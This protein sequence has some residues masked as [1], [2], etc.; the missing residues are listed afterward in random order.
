MRAWLKAQANIA[1]TNIDTATWLRPA[2]AFVQSKQG[3]TS[4][5]KHFIAILSIQKKSDP[6]RLCAQGVP[7]PS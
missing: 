6:A 3:L 1:S 7:H 4:A 5:Y 2:L